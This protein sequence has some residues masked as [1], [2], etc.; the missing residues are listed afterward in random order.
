MNGRLDSM[1]AAVLLA[2]LSVFE[3]E[4]A[5]TGAGGGFL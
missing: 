3:E 1:Q 2:K 5:A 4:L